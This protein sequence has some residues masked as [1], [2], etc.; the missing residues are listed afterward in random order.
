MAK[1]ALRMA[2]HDRQKTIGAVLGIAFAYL[3]VGQ[4]ISTAWHYL[5]QATAYID[6][7]GAD[8]W[9]AGPATKGMLSSGTL[10]PISALHQARVAPHVAWAEPIVKG[11]AWARLP[12]GGARS[13][14]LV[15]VTTPA[16][17]GGPFNLVEGDKSALLRPDAIIVDDVEREKLGGV[18]F[19]DTIEVNR[20]RARV[21]GFTWGLLSTFGAFAF[22]EY[23]NARS[24]L[25]IDADRVSLVLVGVAPGA[26]LERVKE[27]LASRIPDVLVM[28]T[29]E[30]REVTNNFILFDA[31]I[32]GVLG[33]GIFIGFTV[34]LGIVTL[35][36]TGAI[37]QNLR[38]FATLKAI[39]AT[40][41]DLRRLVFIQAMGYSLA[42][43]L[44]GAAVLSEL[45][46]LVRSPR[47]IL[48][49]HPLML[50]GLVPFV[51]SIAL[52]AAAVAIRRLERL[53]PASVF[54]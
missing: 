33:M 1:V 48:M 26:S 32:I 22:A 4:N 5:A 7:S 14:I 51:T 41:G 49:I 45:A 25:D 31:G 11:A 42:G 19:G 24:I 47:L 39:G 21:E 34:G 46:W 29:P 13:L 40:N 15:G 36:M 17:R 50:C 28:T 30:F 53:E 16:L 37:Q 35:A 23:D 27:S 10:L 52:I 6:N 8:L 12:D 3:L 18:N 9:I 44:V 2:Q 43:S 54:R 38:E 20:H